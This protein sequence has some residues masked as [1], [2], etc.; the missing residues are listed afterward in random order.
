MFTFKVDAGYQRK[1]CEKSLLVLHQRSGEPSRRFWVE[2]V[3][4]LPATES[5]NNKHRESHIAIDFLNPSIDVTAVSTS[6]CMRF[7][8]GWP[9]RP[10]GKAQACTHCYRCYST[11]VGSAYSIYEQFVHSL[12]PLLACSLFSCSGHCRRLAALS[13]VFLATSWSLLSLYLQLPVAGENLSR[14]RDI[15]LRAAGPHH[16]MT[17][18]EQCWQAA[19]SV[20][21]CLW[22][23][24]YG[25]LPTSSVYTSCNR[26]FYTANTGFCIWLARLGCC[27]KWQAGV[28]D[29][30]T[31]RWK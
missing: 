3:P 8:W 14:S 17:R 15:C 4:N 27:G 25:H 19:Y 21:D 31:Q 9:G 5:I 18:Q 20:T 29:G 16:E 1:S 10:F 23:K 24:Q 28:D 22:Y 13:H 2:T 26:S 30:C 12:K 7:N 6:A 11:G